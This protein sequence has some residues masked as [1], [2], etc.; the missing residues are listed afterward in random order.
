MPDDLTLL[1]QYEPVIRYNRGELF[2]PCS[3]EDFV[4]GSALF[5]RTDDEP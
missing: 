2:Y 3:V 1:R 5:R 4:A